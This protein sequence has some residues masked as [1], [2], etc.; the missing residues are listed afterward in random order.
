MLQPALFQA[1]KGST[2]NTEVCRPGLL[3][4]NKRR[5]R[6]NIPAY[7]NTRQ[8]PYHCSR[9]CTSPAWPFPLHQPPFLYPQTPIRSTVLTLMSAFCLSFKR[10]PVRVIS[11]SRFKWT[12]CVSIGGHWNAGPHA[13]E[14][15][16]GWWPRSSEFTL[17]VL[18]VHQGM[19]WGGWK[20]FCWSNSLHVSMSVR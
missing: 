18:L 17:G 4:T 15:P 2:I 8:F 11:R 12:V 16:T 3:F 7:T 5:I 6:E 14:G 19:G 13:C 9:W 10:R 1:L 20:V